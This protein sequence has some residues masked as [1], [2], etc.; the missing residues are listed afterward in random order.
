MRQSIYA[1]VQA[2]LFR[3]RDD[4][5][6][7]ENQIPNTKARLLLNVSMAGMGS[8][9]ESLNFDRLWLFAS[10]PTCQTPENVF[11]IK[12]LSIFSSDFGLEYITN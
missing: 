5:P 11:Y 2:M 7:E 1:S 12:R 4:S 10:P 6:A 9:I 8:R 3:E